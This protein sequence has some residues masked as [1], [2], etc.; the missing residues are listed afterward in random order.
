MAPAAS[1][2]A[3]IETDALCG[4]SFHRKHLRRRSAPAGRRWHNACSQEPAKAVLKAANPRE[5]KP[6][7]AANILMLVGTLI[8]VYMTLD[9]IRP[10]RQTK[11]F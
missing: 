4:D 7:F 5:A 8:S 11:P 6:M 3:T 2:R 10:V 1:H 9:F